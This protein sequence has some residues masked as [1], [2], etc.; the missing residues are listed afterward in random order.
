MDLTHFVETQML[1]NLSCR[2]L[3]CLPV[4]LMVGWYLS[5]QSCQNSLMKSSL[6]PLQP[7]EDHHSNVEASPSRLD[8]DMAC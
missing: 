5:N 1:L 4:C 3:I 8:C 7:P 6:E 2:S